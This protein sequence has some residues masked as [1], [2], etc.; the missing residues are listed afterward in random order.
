M[1]RILEGRIKKMVVLRYIFWFLLRCLLALRYRL[2]VHGLDAVRRLRGLVLILPNHP[3]YIDPPLVFAALWPA[4]KPR[5]IVFELMF[6]NPVLRPFTKLLNALR[7]PDL[8]AGA[9][10]QAREQAQ[11]SVN[12]VIAGLKNGENFILWP[13]GRIQRRGVEV[14]GGSRALTEILQAVPEATV[15]L[16]RTTG[17]DRVALHTQAWQLVEHG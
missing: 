13:S 9:S 7:V 11:T 10:A 12:A 15:V 1:V 6:N 8:D 5:P 14:L 3:G 4:L 17:P 2:R 16:V